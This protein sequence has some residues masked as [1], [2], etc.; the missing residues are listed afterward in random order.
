MSIGL[1]KVITRKV[2]TMKIKGQKIEGRN[3]EICI[4]PRGGETPDVIFKCGAVLDI[5]DF[6]KLCP[7]PVVKTKMMKGGKKVDDVDS[8]VYKKASDEHSKKRITYIILRSL[9]DT[10]GLEWET[11][12]IDDPSTW[13]NYE[14]ELKDSGFTNIEVMRIINA[15]MSAN[16]LNDQLIE[17]AR[18]NFLLSQEQASET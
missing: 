11:V 1:A 7:P 8:P 12:K 13:D 5:T 16:C 17:K 14:Q 15:V 6:E 18:A 4:I 3:I 10:E 2:T 9:E